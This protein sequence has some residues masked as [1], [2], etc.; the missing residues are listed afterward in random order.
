MYVLKLTLAQLLVMRH[1]VAFTA[2]SN[3]ILDN[4]LALAPPVDMVNIHRWPV[5]ALTHH[6]FR[7]GIVEMLK[8]YLAMIRHLL[9]FGQGNHSNLCI[10]GRTDSH[11]QQLLRPLLRSASLNS[12][13]RCK[14][15]WF[16]LIFVVSD[17]CLHLSYIEVVEHLI[18]FRCLLP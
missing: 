13:G 3:Q 6:L 16:K 17:N 9:L 8:V 2:E 7:V 15:L 5:T 14:L 4:I 1:R 11:N 10:Y 18:A 12:K